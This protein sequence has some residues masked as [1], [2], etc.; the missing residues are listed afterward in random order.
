MQISI[1]VLRGLLAL[2]RDRGI[3]AETLFAEASIGQQWLDPNVT[4]IDV[5]TFAQAARAAYKLTDDPG[6][7]LHLGMSAPPHTLNMA[8]E[9]LLHCPTIRVALAEIDRY[10]PLV[11]PLARFRLEEAERAHLIFETSFVDPGIDRFANEVTLAFVVR[12]GRHFVSRAEPPIAVRFRHAAP[13]YARA[14][15]IFGCPI[16]FETQHNEVVFARALLDREQPFRDENLHR[17]LKLRA[18]DLLSEKHA[19]VLLRERVKLLLRRAADLSHVDLA[20]VA[21]GLGMNERALRRRLSAES[22]SLSS[23]R[24]EVRRE[25]ALE[26]LTNA[27]LEIKQI[28]DRVGF[29]DVS[30]FHRAFR[31]WTGSTPTRYRT[32]FAAS[33]H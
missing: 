13:S 20:S 16:E 11:L 24:D 29:S 9:V 6:L 30:A 5:Q 25:I 18:D 27:R 14:Y 4:A 32:D 2:L 23:L 17:L 26:S 31:R 1:S 7:A 10:L 15:E 8:G 19:K 12:I 21:R 33:S 28:A 22:S 3:A